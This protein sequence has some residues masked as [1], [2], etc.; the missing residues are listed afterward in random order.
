M[1]RKFL[2]KLLANALIEIRYEASSIKNKKVFWIS[3]LLH[4]LPAEL[5]MV[6]KEEEYKCILEKLEKN[7]EHYGMKK[8]FDYQKEI[9]QE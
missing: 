7:A 1:E 9:G 2:Y 3:D 8:W 4:N 6:T 5:S